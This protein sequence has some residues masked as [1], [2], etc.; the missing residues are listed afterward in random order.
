[1][2][3][4][5]YNHTEFWINESDCLISLIKDVE[6]GSKKGGMTEALSSPTLFFSNASL[7]VA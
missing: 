2:T 6:S 4:E 7:H 5:H 1:M 3:R